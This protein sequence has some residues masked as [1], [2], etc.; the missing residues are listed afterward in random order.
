[1]KT[2]FSLCGKLHRENPVLALYWPCSGLQC[3]LLEFEKKIVLVA[4][5][6]TIFHIH[7]WSRLLKKRGFEA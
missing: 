6:K 1:M 3:R 5:W 2:G 4:Q 7:Y